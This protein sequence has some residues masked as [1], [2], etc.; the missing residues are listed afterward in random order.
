MVQLVPT[1]IQVEADKPFQLHRLNSEQ[2]AMSGEFLACYDHPAFAKN[3]LTKFLV[4]EPL[5]DNSEQ[6]KKTFACCIAVCPAFVVVMPTL[7]EKLT[8]D[9]ADHDIKVEGGGI[10]RPGEFVYFVWALVDKFSKP[11][12]KL[13]KRW[14]KKT[15]QKPTPAKESGT[16]LITGMIKTVTSLISEDED[17][18][19]S[20]DEDEDENEED[21]EFED[22]DEANEEEEEDEDEDEED[23]D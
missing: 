9:G 23:E 1:E 17:E 18:E 7:A 16:A 20:A 13:I 14:C 4:K 2:F 11:D 5:Q 3:I 19:S 8:V 15:G 10:V 12:S 6:M 22:I 21:E